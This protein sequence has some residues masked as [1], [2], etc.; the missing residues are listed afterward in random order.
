MRRIGLTG[1]VASGKSTVLAMFAERG[2]PVFSA[3]SAVHEIYSGPDAARIATEFPQAAVDGAIDRVRLSG[4]LARDPARFRDLEALV[5]PLVRQ[6]AEIFFDG[7]V[8]AGAQLAMIEIPLLYESAHDYGLDAIIVAACD[9]GIW[10][11]RALKR[12]GMNVEKLEQLIARQL[13]LAEKVKRA[14]HVIDT[15]GSLSHTEA[16]VARVL[17]ELRSGTGH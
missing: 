6:K 2:V 8:K 15:G 17:E 16:E 13:P 12:P 4:L 5:H 10:R 7:A 3:D 11:A 1:T 14:D 9:E